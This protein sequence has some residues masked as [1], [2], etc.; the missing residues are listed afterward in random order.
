[1]KPEQRL[2]G[3][4]ALPH[5]RRPENQNEAEGTFGRI[6]LSKLAPQ[7]VQKLI[8]R[9]LAT[10]LSPRRCQYIHAVLRRALG[11]AERFGLVARNVAKLVKAP[12]VEQAEIEP[13]TPEEARAFIQAIRGERLE[14]LYTLSIATG[15]RQAEVL[16][17]SWKDIDLPCAELTVRTTLQRINGE[18]Q[19]LE[20]KTARSR[21][22]LALPDMVVKALRAHKGRQIGEMLQ[23]GTE[24]QETGLVFT[25]EAG[26]PLG[27][28]VVRARFYR[29]LENAGLRRQRFHDLRHSCASL[30]IAQGAGSRE[31]MEQLGHST[32]V[33]T[34]NR[35][36]H[37]FQEVQRESARKMGESLTG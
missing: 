32:I 1:M 37:I 22:T 7:D 26:G 3:L 8:N 5:C 29:I 34:L 2:P 19:F 27:D 4:P 9:K 13:F 16:G 33:M 17:L 30:L 6:P 10:G 23:A 15:L 36:A 25:T 14:A 11:E 24:W 21:R 31:V 20:P 18:F 12:K 35:Y 28:R